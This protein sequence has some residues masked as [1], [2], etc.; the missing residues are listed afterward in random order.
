LQEILI[1]YQPKEPIIYLRGEHI[2]TEFINCTGISEHVI[3]RAKARLRFRKNIELLLAQQ[4]IS[5][6]WLHSK[7]S[8]EVFLQCL[9]KSKLENSTKNL[10][11]ICQSHS[12]AS[13]L[14]QNNWATINFPQVATLQ[15]M[16]E[17]KGKLE[18]IPTPK[19]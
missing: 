7:R 3:Y 4:K 18:L 16:L 19:N 1:N 11:I 14:A 13:V 17:L 6:V 10:N 9:K 5:H 2:S 8:A 12:I 15:A